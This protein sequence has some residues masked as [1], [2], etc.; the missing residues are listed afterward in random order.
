[1]IHTQAFGRLSRAAAVAA[2]LALT[3]AVAAPAGAAAWDPT[4]ATKAPVEPPAAKPRRY[5]TN[6]EM[7]GSIVRRTCKTRDEWIRDEGFDPIR[8]RRQ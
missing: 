6:Q 2:A 4:V 7:T 1:M 5:C 8:V 3:A